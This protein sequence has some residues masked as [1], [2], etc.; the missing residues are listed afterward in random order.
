MLRKIGSH[1]FPVKGR[2]LWL[3]LVTLTTAAYLLIE[4]SFNARL[5]DVVGGNASASDVDSIEVYGRLISGFALALAAWPWLFSRAQKHSY[6][7]AKTVLYLI[8][9]S[10]VLIVVAYHAEKR[11]VDVLVNR[12]NAADRY[13]ALNL[14]LL[15]QALVARD[16][17]LVNLPLQVSDPIR[18]DIKTFLAIFPL[19]ASPIEDLDQKIADRKPLV[20]RNQVDR[21]YGGLGKAYD[22]YRHSTV[23]LQ[24]RYNA[25]YVVASNQA[26]TE[27]DKI[28]GEQA[29]AWNDYVRDLRKHRLQPGT[30]PRMYYGRVRQK[31]QSNGVPVGRDWAPGDRGGF[32]AAVA[33]KAQGQIQTAFANGIAQ[34]FPEGVGLTPYLSWEQF[35]MTPA[36]QR[37][38]KKQLQIPDR[39]TLRPEI[40]TTEQY[41][42]LVY[43]PTLDIRQA[44]NLQQLNAPPEQ[45]ADS[46][47]YE[48]LGK[49]GMRA[50]IVPPIALGFSLLGAMVHIFKFSLGV[51][52]LVTMRAFANGFYKTI[53]ILL[54]AAAIFAVANARA[55]SP[56]TQ[57]KLFVEHLYPDAQGKYGTTAM[58]LVRG[59][60]HLQPVAYPAFE[61]VRRQ[62]LGG[63]TFG[64]SMGT[65]PKV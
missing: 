54:G 3:W 15:Q 2:P 62:V 13:V 55:A 48:K 20:V 59:T 30:V 32:Y 14:H 24:R 63:A 41:A 58:W 8:A 22:D 9:L 34:R 26:A 38:W 42:T 12:S 11:L 21:A 57:E 50:L 35:A 47:P 52:Q 65:S 31:V 17:D 61:F 36:I 27:A 10:G 1:I 43:N 33:H 37:F 5:L 18:P 49:D 64:V 25:D 7:I 45:F 4:F 40:G 19:L 16:V 53:G 39:V 56:I 23:E 29:D 28:P 46:R 44:E 51:T 6:G 60:I